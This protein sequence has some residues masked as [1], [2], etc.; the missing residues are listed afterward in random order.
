MLTFTDDFSRKSWI[1]L[2]KARS[3][4]YGKFTEF[5]AR[6]ELETGERIRAIRCDNTSEYRQLEHLL[7]DRG[8]AMEYTT[9]YTPEQNGVAERLNRSITTMLRSLFA[10][11][12]LPDRLWG[13]AAVTAN[14]L[15]N[16]TPSVP[17][18]MKTPEEMWTGQ[19]PTV[20]QLKVFGCI[21]YAHVPVA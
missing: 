2:T 21:A 8:I 12:E 3:E 19:E 7:A 17:G 1:Y 20:G 9:I 18:S 11:A 10:D 5:A 4:L 16:W 14:D 6:V 13:E 15:R